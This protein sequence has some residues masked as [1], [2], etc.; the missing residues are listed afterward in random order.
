MMIRLMLAASAVLLFVIGVTVADDKK[1]EPAQ[2][3]VNGTFV[4][5]DADK[6]EI[7][8]KV[9]GKNEM[10]FRVSQDAKIAVGEVKELKKLRT[11]DPII[12]TL[13]RDG[14]KNMVIEVRQGKQKGSSSPSPSQ[15]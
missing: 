1:S 2:T 11:D 9:N 7:T 6:N 14:D 13:T 5:F 8:I 15:I 10:T 3:E 12:L 4:K